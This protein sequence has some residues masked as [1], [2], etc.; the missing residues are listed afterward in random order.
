MSYD[1]LKQTFNRL[2]FTC[3]CWKGCT[4][5]IMQKSWRNVTAWLISSL[6]WIFIWSFRCDPFK[7]QSLL[8]FYLKIKCEEQSQEVKINCHSVIIISQESIQIIFAYL[9]MKVL[10][11]N[12]LLEKKN[13][14][15][16]LLS[17]AQE[18]HKTVK[19]KSIVV[20]LTRYTVALDNIVPL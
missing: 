13:H 19:W 12:L 14:V 18:R 11:M 2:Y 4:K 9:V 20:L 17:L 7:H 5:I 16:L 10:Y 15:C 3:C 1:W 8:P 6:I